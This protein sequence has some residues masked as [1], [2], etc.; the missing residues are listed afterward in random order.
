MKYSELY[1]EKS[2]I[3][4]GTN[5]TIS[6]TDTFPNL[7]KVNDPIDTSIVY[8][9]CKDNSL[10]NATIDIDLGANNGVI[11]VYDTIPIYSY[12]YVS[13]KISLYSAL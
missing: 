12:L 1:G 7:F 3:S 2:T 13:C 6:L 4:L 5:E 11:Y 9:T 8:T 10:R